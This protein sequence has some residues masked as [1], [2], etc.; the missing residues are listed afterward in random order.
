MIEP[1]GVLR[2]VLDPGD[3]FAGN[4]YFEMNIELSGAF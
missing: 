4:N 2:E 3:F 1:H